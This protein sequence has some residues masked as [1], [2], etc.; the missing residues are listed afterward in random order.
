MKTGNQVPNFIANEVYAIDIICDKLACF[1]SPKPRLINALGTQLKMASE[2]FEALPEAAQQHFAEARDAF[3]QCYPLIMGDAFN[4]DVAINQLKPILRTAI[5]NLT[6]D[7]GLLDRYSS[8]FLTNTWGDMFAVNNHAIVSKT[9]RYGTIISAN[10]KFIEISGYTLEELIG[11]DHAILNSGL[12]VKGFFKEVWH[13][14][15]NGETWHG[16]ICNRNKQGDLYWVESTIQPIFNQDNEIEHFISI[17]TDVTGLKKAQLQAEAS[18]LEWQLLLDSV[19][20]MILYKDTR[21]N[22]IKANPTAA[23]WFGLPSF[24][25]EGKSSEELW[26]NTAKSYYQA[27]LEVIQ[28]QKPKIGIVEP[29]ETLHKKMWVRT[30]KFPI[31]DEKGGVKGILV[32]AIDI[33][34]LKD[35]EEALKQ[36]LTE[37]EKAKQEAESANRAKSEFLSS[38][39][40]E[41]RTPLN[42]VLGF[43]ELL[44]NSELTDKQARQLQNIR[45]SGQ[46]LL[47]LINQ[48]L[49]LSQIETGSLSLTLNRVNMKSVIESSLSTI[50]P[51][52]ERSGIQVSHVSQEN[53]NQDVYADST[54]VKQVLLNFLSNA[55]KYNRPDGEVQIHCEQT[56]NGSQPMFRVSVADT[57]IGIAADKQD[58]VFEPFNRLGLESKT[59][60]GTGIGLSITEKI[61]H[62]MGG[63]IG[64]NSVEGE[65]SVF[66]FELPADQDDEY[67]LAS[68]QK[69]I[70][71]QGLLADSSS[72]EKIVKLPHN[73]QVLYIEDNPMNMQLMSEVIEMLDGFEL[74]IAPMA[75]IGIE[76]A[77]ELLPDCIFIDLDLPGMGG[78][79]GF[80][81]LSQIQALIDKGTKM[82]ALTAK[83]MAHEIEYGMQLGFD[84]YL[85]KPMDV[86]QVMSL[87]QNL[88]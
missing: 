84:G 59:I 77:Q 26:P 22:I 45:Q 35:V 64:F 58:K 36:K 55:I 24:E 48:V 67:D 80:K 40:H 4:E 47:E 79:E 34:E 81:A 9:D 43:S 21:N 76:K 17:R 50:Q 74:T 54:R 60:E 46:H 87:L 37:L 82:Y 30:D 70:F 28:S 53:C 75:E 16:T 12:Q 49:E 33:T 23:K 86:K 68:L 19:G 31:F 32:S 85:T 41:L 42:S 13:T 10:P 51:M 39:S 7:D 38:M 69:Q 63:E 8:D 44:A 18:E 88:D 14:I 78:E 66:W 27:D 72:Q 1:N 61:V 57:G 29:F 2:L 52:A 6:K 25:M 11:E 56:L 62:L 5:D 65:G 20:A 83:A 73:K 3:K 15:V 71:T